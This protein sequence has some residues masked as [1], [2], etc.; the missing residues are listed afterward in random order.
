[1][2]PTNEAKLEIAR[3]HF[4][5]YRFRAAYHAYH[6]L[7]SSLPFKLDEVQLE[8]IGF[9]VRVLHEL[10]RVEELRFYIP[11]LEKYYGIRPTD[12]L[13]YALGYVYHVL[14]EKIRPRELFE[15][16][17]ARTSDPELKIKAI[18]MLARL[19]DTTEESIRLIHSI[20]GTAKEPLLANFLEVW[21][22]IVIRYQ[23]NAKESSLKLR[24]L[25]STLSTRPGDKYCLLAAKDALVRSELELL[26][27][28]DARREIEELS[29]LSNTLEM[30]TARMHQSE[31]NVVYNERLGAQRI[32]HRESTGSVELSYLRRSVQIQNP[33]V[34]GLIRVFQESPQLTLRKVRSFLDVTDRQLDDV[35]NRFLEKLDRLALPA[36]SLVR[37]GARIQLLPAFQSPP[38]ETR[39]SVCD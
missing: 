19:T 36:D 39:R 33:Q 34:R 16:V 8:H 9:Y 22:C 29:V 28:A 11:T 3:E 27:F 14:G 6:K 2:R 5:S 13:A 37:Q 25:A 18:M 21:R 30:R 20:E 1:M 17:R 23:G 26:H 31:L 38:K 24:A 15:R 32:L 4:Y 7:F 35:V 10:D 12:Q